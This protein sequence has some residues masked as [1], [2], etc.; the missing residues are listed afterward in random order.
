M[1]AS[2]DQYGYGSDWASVIGADDADV[3]HMS[4]AL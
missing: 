4:D 2:D 3:G 1:M